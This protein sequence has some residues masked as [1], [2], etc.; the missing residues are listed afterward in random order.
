MH[1]YM[2]CGHKTPLLHWQ[3]WKAALADPEGAG[4]GLTVC[5]A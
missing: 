4:F 3:T 2:A 1:G 5:R